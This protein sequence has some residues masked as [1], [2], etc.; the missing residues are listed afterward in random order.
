M[1]EKT[2]YLLDIFGFKDFTIFCG[3]GISKN[4]GLPLA[5]ELLQYIIE[6]LPFD[7][8]D[9]EEIVA[10]N[11]PFEAFM[12]SL[13]ENTDISKILDIFKEGEPNTAH[14]LIARLAKNGYLKTIFTTNFDLLIEKALEKEGLKKNNDFEVYCNEEQFS[15]IDFECTEG[16]IIRILKIHGSIDDK[17]SIRTTMKAVASKTLS[18]KRMKVIEYLLSTGRHKKVLILGYSCSDVFD[19]TPQIQSIEKNQKEIIFVEHSKEG[20]EIEDVRI[21]E[22]PF[23][24]FPGKR[25]KCNTDDFIR[26]LWDSLKKT[27]GEYT[28]I[29]SEV[30]WKTYLEDW[31][32]GLKKK[33]LKYFIAGL[34]L[35]EISNFKRAIEYHEKSLE[36]AKAIGDKEEEARC[37]TCLGISHFSL[38]NFKRGVEYH[39]KALE[40]AKA[41]K[42]KIGE[43]IAHTNLGNAY[44]NLGD[45]KRAVEHHEKALEIAKAI[46]DKI[47]ESACY[48]NLGNAYR[49]LG[50]F[51]RA[52][53]YYEK[54]LEI[55]KEI[56]GKAEEARCYV[57]LG[58]AYYDL[59]DIKRAIEHHEKALE[60][61]KAIGD[62]A[63]ES[64]CYTNLGNAYRVSG[65]FTIA[66]EY[67]E[68]SLEIAKAIGIEVV[69]SACYTN[70]GNAYRNLGDIKKAVEYLEKALEIKKAI[71]DKAG[72]L[73]CNTGLGNAYCGLGDIK[74]AVEYLEKALEISIEIRDK[75]RESVCYANLGNAYRMSGDF[76]RAIEYL[77]KSE[78]IFKEN[79]Q[80]HYLKNVYRV[81]ALT[82]EK[83]GDNKNEKHYKGKLI[84]NTKNL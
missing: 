42:D 67:H 35:Y 7:K 22:L 50:D 6:K 23:K 56:G 47:G 52:I 82:Y 36:I 58:N 63:G 2:S 64:A 38:G 81:L 33:Y 70:L 11:F 10:S 16:K 75:A 62:K 79:G 3:A 28:P 83:M 39:K 29:E 27:I 1:N 74:K 78:K 5:N 44:R 59:G 45:F 13:S 19:I 25:I 76:K 49:N 9:I 84:S 18:D 51:K 30:D 32:K 17:N 72:K 15:R 31:A 48:T 43:S 61:K 73:A 68:W 24:T 41:I 20:T 60:I 55:A 66:I 71:G 46:R 69:E 8:K 37:Y 14:I 54:S 4:S 26:E 77:F 53:E 21:K 40:I 12:E 34:I 57:G 65:D 80:T